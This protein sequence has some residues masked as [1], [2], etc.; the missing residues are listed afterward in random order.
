MTNLDKTLKLLS[1]VD[2]S[3]NLLQYA[4]RIELKRQRSGHYRLYV[5]CIGATKDDAATGCLEVGD[6]CGFSA[7][8][9]R[10]AGLLTSVS[11]ADN[12]EPAGRK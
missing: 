9:Y 10:K 1:E 2:K 6:L 5:A 8:P 3:T 12:D 4:D 7:N 11:F